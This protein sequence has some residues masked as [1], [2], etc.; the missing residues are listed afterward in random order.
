M[1]TTKSH[2]QVRLQARREW[3]PSKWNDQTC[4]KSDLDGCWFTDND[5]KMGA[6]KTTGIRIIRRSLRPP[7]VLQL[8][9][10]L[11]SGVCSDILLYHSLPFHPL[12]SAT[13][14]WT[15][16]W[17]APRQWDF[18]LDGISSSSGRRQGCSNTLRARWRMSQCKCGSWLFSIP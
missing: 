15:F 12:S 7:E 14:I 6:D 11:L 17:R 10:K 18:V 1:E 13:L 9:F 4:T 5:T 16:V 8:P 2:F 3:Q